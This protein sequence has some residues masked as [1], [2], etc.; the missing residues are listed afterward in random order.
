MSGNYAEI[1][2]DSKNEYSVDGVM[3]GGSWRNTAHSGTVTNWEKGSTT[4]YVPG[5]TIKEL[6]AIDA[7]YITVRLIYAMDKN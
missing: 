3:C 4:E 5:T 2:Y 1:C 7:R 6:N